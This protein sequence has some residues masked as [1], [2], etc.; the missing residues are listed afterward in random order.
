MR[1]SLPTDSDGFLTQQCAS[2][3]QQF[4]VVFGEGSDQPLAYCPYCGFNGDA[5]L[6]RAQTEYAAA[7]ANNVLVAP[8]LKKMGRD[9]KRSTGGF[10]DMKTTVPKVPPPPIDVDREYA[11][12]RFPCCNETIKAERHDALFCVICGGEVNLNM[13]DAKKVFLSHKGVDKVFVREFKDALALMGYDPWIDE[14]AMPA[15]TSLERGLLKGMQESCGVVFFLTPSFKDQ[16]FLQTEVDYAV[17]EKRS[18]GDAFAIIALQ[19]EDEQGNVGEIPELLK[20]YVWKKPKS[21]LQALCEIVKALPVKAG[22]VDWRDGI[23]GVVQTPKVKSKSAELSEEAKAILLAA[24]AGDG[25]VMHL[26]HLGGEEIQAGRQSMVPDGDKRT[27]VRWTG[28][29]EDLLRRG[30]L[31]DRGHKGEVFEVT[32]EGYEAA[33]QLKGAA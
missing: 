2:C 31:R 30:Y 17:N 13:S 19:F 5:W 32:R 15:G 7:V 20:H 33:D 24:T 10:L 27:V 3:G 26:R 28:G 1:I 18:K 12:I 23:T 4:K 21:N 8:A 14:D 9:L 25:S 22:D 16:G 29:L 11:F 6:T